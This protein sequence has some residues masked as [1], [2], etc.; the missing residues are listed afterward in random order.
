M[1]GLPHCVGFSLVASS[2]G[3]FPVMAQG[4]LLAVASPVAEHRLKSA[5]ASVVAVRAQW[6]WLLSCRIQAQ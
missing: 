2:G 3:H 4:L 1:L 5:Q 6:L